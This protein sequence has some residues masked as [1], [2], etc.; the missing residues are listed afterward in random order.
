[1]ISVEIPKTIFCFGWPLIQNKNST[2]M[3]SLKILKHSKK[4]FVT[5]I[6]RYF[7]HKKFISTRSII[8]IVNQTIFW[9]LGTKPTPTT[10]TITKL[11]LFAR[12][13]EGIVQESPN[14]IHSRISCLEVDMDLIFQNDI[15]GSYQK[16][17]DYLIMRSK[18]PQMNGVDNME[19]H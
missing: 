13:L 19:S 8:S 4:F 14:V 12:V 17:K 18:L 1:M 9:L 2:L 3:I 15:Y 11:N 10:R 6:F 5:L 16:I 7:Q